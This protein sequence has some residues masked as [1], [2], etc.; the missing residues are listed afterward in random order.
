MQ[1]QTPLIIHTMQLQVKP[2]RSLLQALYTAEG[3]V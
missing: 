1:T 3:T 2:Q